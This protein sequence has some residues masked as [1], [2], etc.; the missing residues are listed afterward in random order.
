MLDE[1]PDG[2]RDPTTN[3]RAVQLG[4]GHADHA[5]ITLGP[6]PPLE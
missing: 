3:L 4:I 1:A 6:L 5:P 2:G